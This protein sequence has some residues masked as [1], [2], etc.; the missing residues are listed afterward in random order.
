MHH[1]VSD[2]HDHDDDGIQDLHRTMVSSV[3]HYNSNHPNN[4]HLNSNPSN[5]FYHNSNPDTNFYPNSNPD[6]NFYHNSN[7]HNNFHPNS[8]PP[9]NVRINSETAQSFGQILSHDFI[10]RSES[11]VTKIDH[12]KGHTTAMV[13]DEEIQCVFLNIHDVNDSIITKRCAF[14]GWIPIVIRHHVNVLMEDLTLDWVGKHLIWINGRHMD[15]LFLEYAKYDG[16][17]VARVPLENSIN[18]LSIHCDPEIGYIFALTFRPK[19]IHRMGMDGSDCKV[20]FDKPSTRPAALALDSV[21]SLI[22]F[23]AGLRMFSMDYEGH[24]LGEVGIMTGATFVPVHYHSMQVSGS[25]IIWSSGFMPLMSQL[26]VANINEL[27]LPEATNLERL[28][29]GKVK[30]F[31]L[32]STHQQSRRNISHCY[33]AEHNCGSRL[34]LATGLHRH[35]CMDIIGQGDDSEEDDDDSS[36]VSCPPF[37]FQCE[38]TASCIPQPWTCDGDADCA[39]SS[40]PPNRCGES[41]LMVRPGYVLL[42]SHYYKFH[43][44]MGTFSEANKICVAEDGHQLVVG[45][46]DLLKVIQALIEW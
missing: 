23:I 30:F 33:E 4:F 2:D 15:A 8:N 37:S 12:A 6:T 42:G 28:D 3:G 34:C 5:N 29:L 21:N 16:S 27:D 46:P 19:G 41:K 10:L 11:N 36:R 32:L 26:D 35:Q 9:S 17:V 44:E 38:S 43:Q 7:P 31:Q 25:R 20:L 40:A 13:F 45:D 39:D 24:T 18:P 22:Y 14:N 1:L